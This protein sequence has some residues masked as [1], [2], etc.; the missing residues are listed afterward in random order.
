VQYTSGSIF[1]IR[2]DLLANAGLLLELHA[3]PRTHFGIEAMLSYRVR[4]QRYLVLEEP[5]FALAR[6]A[7][8]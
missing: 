6:L 4:H 7:I 2:A 5:V 1:K 8:Q 3:T